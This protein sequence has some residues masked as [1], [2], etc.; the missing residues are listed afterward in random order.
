MALEMPE[1]GFVE[2]TE[3]DFATTYKLGKGPKSIRVNVGRGKAFLLT[4][5]FNDFIHE[6][7]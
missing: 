1:G 3:E 6:A 4:Q 7:G 5:L 2:T